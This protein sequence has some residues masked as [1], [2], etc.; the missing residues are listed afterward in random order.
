MRFLILSALLLLG[1]SGCATSAHN[2]SKSFTTK[3]ISP[4]TEVVFAPV[5]SVELVVPG[6]FDSSWGSGLR[7]DGGAAFFSELFNQSFKHVVERG[8]IVYDSSLK[9]DTLFRDT[10]TVLLRD[11]TRLSNRK[12]WDEHRRDR[13][14]FF[15]GLTAL[16]DTVSL[17]SVG[18][19]VPDS[20]HQ[21]Y[22]AREALQSAGHHPDL[23]IVITRILFDTTR[24]Y[25]ASHMGAGG[26]SWESCVGDEVWIRLDYMVWDHVA[27]GPAAF[28]RVDR[29]SE[30]GCGLFRRGVGINRLKWLSAVDLATRDIVNGTPFAGRKN[31]GIRDPFM[32][33]QDAE[34]EIQAYNSI[35][36][37]S[38]YLKEKK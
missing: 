5:R 11:T 17:Y 6:A 7:T 1:L 29:E 30:G 35:D 9:D 10:V 33:F 38:G 31:M 14:G 13:K 18:P 25:E 26:T 20:V 37:F 15:S 3:R 12:T 22:L 23:S 27:S 16:T 28:G 2:R 4:A 34:R 8:R 19:K 21:S 32:D 24:G 36:Y